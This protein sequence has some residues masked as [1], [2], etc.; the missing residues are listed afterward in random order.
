MVY[1]SNDPFHG[2]IVRCPVCNSPFSA[3]G[4]GPHLKSHENKRIDK[5][6]ERGSV[7]LKRR[8][9]K[10]AEILNQILKKRNE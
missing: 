7:S 6:T 5:R 4:L 10:T 3:K 8:K 2:L 9:Q 1:L